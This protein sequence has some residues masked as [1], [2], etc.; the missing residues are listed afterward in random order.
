MCMILLLNSLCSRDTGVPEWYILFYHLEILSQMPIQ[1]LL[2]V[3][4]DG[5]H[6]SI[7]GL[8]FVPYLRISSSLAR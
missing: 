2:P 8:F 1:F 4:Q 6:T 3:I 5:P 7:K